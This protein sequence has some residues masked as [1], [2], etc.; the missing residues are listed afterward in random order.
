MSLCDK[1]T[2]TSNGGVCHAISTGN[3]SINSFY[4]LLLLTRDDG[5]NPWTRGRETTL[6]S[7]PG[8]CRTDKHNYTH[9]HSWECLVSPIHLTCMSLDFGKTQWRPMQTQEDKFHTERTPGT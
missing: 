9:I 1:Q 3:Q 5:A 8:H 6:D 2:L 7:S 4:K